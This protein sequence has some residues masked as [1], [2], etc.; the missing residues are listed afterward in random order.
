MK[1][2]CVQLNRLPTQT[3]TG[4]TV[5]HLRLFLLPSYEYTDLVKCRAG[6]S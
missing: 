6:F 2:F 3:G 1:L 5:Y 4:N